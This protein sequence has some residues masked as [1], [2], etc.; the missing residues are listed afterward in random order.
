MRSRV[1]NTRNFVLPY[2]EFKQRLRERMRTTIASPIKV[3][4]IGLHCGSECTVELRPAPPGS[5]RR[6]NGAPISLAQVS[7]TTLATTLMTPSGPV[8]VVEHLFAALHGIGIDDI[9]INARRSKS[10]S[11]M[12]AQTHGCSSSNRLFTQDSRLNQFVFANPSPSGTRMLGCGQSRLMNC[13]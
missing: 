6:L 12:A 5:G 10:Q 11:S 2:R 8:A 9:D 4:G 7:G 1:H 3:R 13:G